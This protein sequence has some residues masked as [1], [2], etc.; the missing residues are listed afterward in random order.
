MLKNVARIVIDQIKSI[1]QHW[2]D[3]QDYFLKMLSLS[4][5]IKKNLFMLLIFFI[6]H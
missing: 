6:S 1:L 5:K 3:G 2:D 4:L